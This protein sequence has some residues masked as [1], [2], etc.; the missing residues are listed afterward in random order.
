[1]DI[2]DKVRQWV[3]GFP[4]WEEGNLL[5]I[6]DMDA[7]PGSM[8]FF[9]GG[10]EVVSAKANVLGGVKMTCRYHFAL[11]RV[12]NANGDGADAR[13]LAAFQTWVLEQTAR[14][15]APVFGDEPAME[16]IVAEKGA[17]KDNH[18]PGTGI[19]M[20]KLTA[21]FVKNYEK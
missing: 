12:G 7:V 9:P 19:Y 17:L 11:Y 20:V 8:G 1:M 10:L 5:Y 21:T 16:R 13:W 18:Q 14:G 2:L 6:D 3:T 15:L 4:L